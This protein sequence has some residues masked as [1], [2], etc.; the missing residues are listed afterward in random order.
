MN[1]HS[2]FYLAHLGDMGEELKALAQQRFIP[3]GKE[4]QLLDNAATALISVSRMHYHLT[5]LFELLAELNA[6]YP[7]QIT[8]EE[9]AKKVI[10]YADTYI[11]CAEERWQN[12]QMAITSDIGT[13]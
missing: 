1:S 9:A 11:K 7:D 13:A 2:R 6:R 12:F 4:Y 8:S 10:L 5:Q 3:G